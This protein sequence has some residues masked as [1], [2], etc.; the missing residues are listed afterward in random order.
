[1]S[2]KEKTFN[3]LEYDNKFIK[4]NYIQFAFRLRKSSDAEAIEKIKSVPNKSDY[5]RQLILKDIA[6]E[7][8]NIKGS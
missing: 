4:E 7:K 5:L 2:Q 6:E 3:K 8:S 1:M